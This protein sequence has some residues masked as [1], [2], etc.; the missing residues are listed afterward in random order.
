MGRLSKDAWAA[1]SCAIAYQLTSG[2]ER[3]DYANKTI[4]ILNAWATINKTTSNVDGNLAMA[5]SGVGLVLAAELLTDYDGWEKEQRV[6]FAEWLRNVHL[7]SCSRIA[8]HENNWGDW[9]VLG[10]IAAHYFLD[11]IKGIDADIE[12]IRMHIDQA[13]EA[14]GRMPQET[15]RGK[16]GMWYT[17]FALAPLTAACQIAYNARGVDL[18][19]YKGKDGAGIEQALDYLYQY[20]LEPQK[21]PH[22]TGKGLALPEPGKWPGNLFEAMSGIYGKKEYEVWV[23]NARPLIVSSHHYAWSVPTLLR[24]VPLKNEAKK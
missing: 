6:Q 24:T 10:C 2:K 18:F 16:N 19:N 20:S 1:Y 4:Q 8:G 17:Y 12:C 22:F 5:D 21:W 23:E 11:D 15:K 7:K 9:G 13:I 14:D 3:I